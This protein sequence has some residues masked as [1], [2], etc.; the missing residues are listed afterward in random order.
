MQILELKIYIIRSSENILS[1]SYP[2]CISSW[3]IRIQ[4]S[5]HV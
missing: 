2:E 4:L 3:Q 1:L 5:W